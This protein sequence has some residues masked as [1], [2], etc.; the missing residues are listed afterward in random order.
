[1]FHKF[2]HNL[3]IIMYSNHNIFHYYIYR[4]ISLILNLILYQQNNLNNNLFIHH[5]IN[6]LNH[7]KF[8]QQF[9]ISFSHSKRYL[10]DNLVS[11]HINH[12]CKYGLV[13]ILY[14]L[15]LDPL[16]ILNMTHGILNI[17]NLVDPSINHFHIQKYI[18]MY[19]YHKR[20]FLK[21]LYIIDIYFTIN[22][23]QHSWS[24]YH[25]NHRRFLLMIIF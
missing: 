18:T 23:I 21:E 2:H 4:D 9:N 15:L 12:L 24:L 13:S 11:I 22:H 6:S 14:S 17:V 10:Q 25:Y 8:H 20:V 5:I 19:L 7:I 16:D 1:M 3:H